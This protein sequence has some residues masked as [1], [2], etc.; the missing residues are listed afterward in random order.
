LAHVLTTTRPSAAGFY[1]GKA[2]KNQKSTQCQHIDAPPVLAQED[3][4]LLPV[5][6]VCIM[7]LT[8]LDPEVDD[9]LQQQF[10][11]DD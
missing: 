9:Q 5:P 4:Y 2:D 8:I 7:T 10:Y 11:E 1:E 3:T 6:E